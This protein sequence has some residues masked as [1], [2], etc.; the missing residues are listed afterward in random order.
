M[1]EGFST[2]GTKAILVALT[3]LGKV[4]LEKKNLIA[5]VKSASRLFQQCLKKKAVYPSGSG[6]R[7]RK[8]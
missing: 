8:L 4:L 7:L 3:H 6:D 5:L 1:H 2:F